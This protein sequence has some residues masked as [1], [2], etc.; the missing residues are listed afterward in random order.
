VLKIKS[1]STALVLTTALLVLG[2][3]S[4]SGNTPTTAN[5]AQSVSEVKVFKGMGQTSVFR[6]GPGKDAEGGQ[7]YSLAYATAS[8]LFDKDG[9]V[10][11]VY[12]DALEVLSPNDAEHQGV[13]KFSGWPT[14]PGYLKAASNTDDTAA[15]E[16]KAWQTKRERGDAAYGM[17]WS[18][19]F[20]VF[21]DFFKGKT[22]A[23]I[24]QW[25]AKNT[26]DLNGRPLLKD[27]TKP[28][29]QAKYAKLTD[30]EKTALADV[31]SGA[32]ISLNDAHGDYIG[33]LKEAFANKVEVTIPAK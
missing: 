29:D 22:I 5:P 30:A 25:Y 33:A 21:Q 12:F 32:T 23:E 13:P 11:D 3:C 31:T 26:S 7:I 8:A 10:I 19:Q 6:V 16:V 28:E 18:E 1:I 15:K 20:A 27:A 14:Q 4:A 9:K 17:D 24:E 2:G